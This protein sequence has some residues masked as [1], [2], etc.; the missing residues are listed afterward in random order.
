LV[1]IPS[2]GGTDELGLVISDRLLSGTFSW[3]GRVERAGPARSRAERRNRKRKNRRDENYSSASRS[4]PVDAK[5][6]ERLGGVFR[7]SEWW[8]LKYLPESINL[9]N[10]ILIVDF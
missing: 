1:K 2:C 3:D 6:H 9:S 10:F 8:E 7:R 5:A 4:P